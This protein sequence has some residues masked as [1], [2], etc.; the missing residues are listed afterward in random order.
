[1]LLVTPAT[2]TAWDTRQCLETDFGSVQVL[3]PAG[4]IHLKSPRRSGQDED[5]IRRLKDLTDEN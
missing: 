2:Q 1:L 3:S 4:L 5:D